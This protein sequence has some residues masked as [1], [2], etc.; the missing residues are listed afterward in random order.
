ML[1]RA[2]CRPSSSPSLCPHYHDLL[3]QDRKA[4]VTSPSE[5]APTRL[6]LSAPPWA[7]LA[8]GTA[9]V[10][11]TRGQRRRSPGPRSHPP[12]VIL[13]HR[14]RTAGSRCSVLR[15]LSCQVLLNAHV[16]SVCF[17]CFRGML[18]VFQMDVA[19][20]NRDVAYVAMVV[21]VFRKGMLP[22]FHVFLDV[23]RKCVYLN[24]VYI[25]THMMQVFYLDVAMFTM[26]SSVFRCFC[27]CFRNMFQMFHLFSYVYCG[28]IWM[29]QN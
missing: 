9:C 17:E 28:C 27:K 2:S 7:S 15:L 19:K 11:I 25:F 4:A 3:P 14:C 21:H 16:A 12:A 8:E 23:Y 22:M 10:P 26:V 18:Q 29:F 13:L 6:L 1:R 24:V 5:V 20:V